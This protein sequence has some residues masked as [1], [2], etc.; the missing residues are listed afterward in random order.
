VYVFVCLACRLL[1]PWL[2]TFC[3]SHLA[4]TCNENYNSPHKLCACFYAFD[5]DSFDCGVD[6]V[7][8]W[9]SVKHAQI[10]LVTHR[11]SSAWH[12]CLL[13]LEN[14]VYLWLFINFDFDGMLCA[15]FYVCDF[16]SF[17]TVGHWSSNTKHLSL[18]HWSSN[19]KHLSLGHCS[20][21][22][23]HLLSWSKIVVLI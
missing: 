13:K 17:D 11:S 3:K 7:K 23:K 9:D 18:G 14:R 6:S 21:N 5:F 16:V 4:P 12:W 8:I 19:T 10:Y 22:R 1:P 15:C 20:S 2:S